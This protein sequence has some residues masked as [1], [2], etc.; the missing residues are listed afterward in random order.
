MNTI[1]TNEIHRMMRRNGAFTRCREWV[2]TDREY[3]VPTLDMVKSLMAKY[4]DDSIRYI[5]S[6]CEC[7]EFALFFL[8]DVR[9]GRCR[10]IDDLPVADRKN[11]A[12]GEA[13]GGKWNGVGKKHHANICVTEDGLYLFDM[14]SQQIWQPM[15]GND[16]I[17]FV[18]F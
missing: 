6:L 15:R 13:L 10:D 17:Y 7:E 14:Q 18:R 4:A 8:A 11:L 12:I 3:L 2:S 9:R 16:S 1:T 5:P